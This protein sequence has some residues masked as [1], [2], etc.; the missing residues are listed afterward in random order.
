M[1]KPTAVCVLSVSPS[2]IDSASYC[3]DDS[4]NAEPVAREA[5][6]HSGPAVIEA[7][8]DRNEPPF[9][10]KGTTARAITFTESLP[11]GET[12]R[13]AIVKDVLMDQVREVVQVIS[14]SALVGAACRD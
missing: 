6:A 7:V 4:A 14:M 11:R 3:I 5:L 8:V 13:S 2:N 1:A 10:A 12:N 9:P